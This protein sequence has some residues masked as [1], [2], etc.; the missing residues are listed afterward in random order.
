MACTKPAVPATQTSAQLG[1]VT[2]VPANTMLMMDLMTQAMACDLTRFITMPMIPQPTAP[3]LNLTEIL[4]D[5][6]AHKVDAGDPTIRAKLNQFQRW[7]AQMVAYLLNGMKG[8][9]EGGGTLL[10]HS[11]VLW[12]DELGDPSV[13][14]SFDIPTVLCGGVNG[15][16]RMGRYL[17]LRPGL[18]PLD[19]WN[20]VGDKAPNAVPHNK[21]L[22][23]IAQAFGQ[24]IMTFG[25]T[26]FTSARCLASC[27][28]RRVTL[29]QT[30]ITFST[31]RIET[32]TA[33][34]ASPAMSPE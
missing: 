11:L 6:L 28:R 3:W 20:G 21:L 12:G 17:Q 1:D 10:D 7:N 15:A 27:S 25:H 5:D 30:S 33:T 13:H 34:M 8:I 23:S 24:N 19:G 9:S 26:D 18:A 32:M 2:N 4:H 16:F 29:F 31:A 14:A 22:V